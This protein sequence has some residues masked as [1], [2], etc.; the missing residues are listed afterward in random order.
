[1]SIQ[2]RAVNFEKYQLATAVLTVF[3]TADV[4]TGIGST[5]PHILGSYRMNVGSLLEIYT[6]M[7]GWSIYNSMFD[8]FR[9]TGL[10]LVP[11]IFVLI[12]NWKEPLT[13]AK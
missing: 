13:V 2:N 10:L 12:K 5:Q 11:F 6:T 8:L 3:I 4:N 9:A 1:M 7:F